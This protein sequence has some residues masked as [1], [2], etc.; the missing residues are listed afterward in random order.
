MKVVVCD[1]DGYSVRAPP[2]Q[3][4]NVAYRLGVVGHL[5]FHL[6]LAFE[7]VLLHISER[8]LR[9][10]NESVEVGADS[11][12]VCCPRFLDC[13]SVIVSPLAV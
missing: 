3:G 4:L 11:R 13:R 2:G 5:L 8:F 10:V 1:R 6:L 7:K 9:V 12:A